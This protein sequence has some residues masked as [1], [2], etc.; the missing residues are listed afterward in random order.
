MW[1]PFGCRYTDGV[2]EHCAGCMHQ[3]LHAYIPEDIWLNVFL[4]TFVVSSV[5]QKILS[6]KHLIKTSSK[7]YVI[8]QE[9]LKYIE[10]SGDALLFNK[11]A[12]KA[13][14]GKKVFLRLEQTSFLGPLNDLSRETLPRGAAFSSVQRIGL[15]DESGHMYDVVE[16]SDGTT[17]L[18]F[19]EY[20]MYYMHKQF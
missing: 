8:P 11:N 3:K 5:T 10:K 4:S 6:A 13:I 12:A 14:K 9:A 20:M 2:C 7:E 1:S 18:Y 15:T 19:S 16:L 17:M